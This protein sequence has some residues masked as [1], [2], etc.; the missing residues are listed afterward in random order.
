MLEAVCCNGY[1]GQIWIKGEPEINEVG[2]DHVDEAVGQDGE[3]LTRR[4]SI[5]WVTH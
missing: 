5:H 4:R 2:E 3:G 1:L